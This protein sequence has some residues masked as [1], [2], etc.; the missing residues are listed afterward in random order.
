MTEIA[1][2][3]KRRREELGLT[4]DDLAQRMGYK[5]RSSINKIEN[6]END[7]PQAKIKRF[8]EELHTT[9]MYLLGLED[10]APDPLDEE[11]IRLYNSLGEREQALAR[12]MLEMLAKSGGNG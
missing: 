7:I 6:G 2:R 8:A 1:I 5:S 3:I 11:I 12:E 4:Q 9:P 10:S